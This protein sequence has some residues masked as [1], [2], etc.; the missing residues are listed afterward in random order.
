MVN[1]Q[2]R[3]DDR[4]S[5]KPYRN[6]PQEPALRDPMESRP[7]RRSRMRF[8][9]FLFFGLFALFI[10]YQEAPEV[11]NAVDSLVRPQAHAARKACESAVLAKAEKPDFA[12]IIRRGEFIE[13]RNGFLVKGVLLGEMDAQGQERQTPHHCYLDAGGSVVSSEKSVE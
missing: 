1:R 3:P 4:T 5:R 9:P 8:L 10:L 2:M 13:T 6:P 11:Q 12:R 7:R